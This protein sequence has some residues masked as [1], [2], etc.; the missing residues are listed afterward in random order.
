MFSYTIPVFFVLLLAHLVLALA[1][2]EAMGE[3]LA[4]GLA[5]TVLVAL[6]E[7][8][9]DGDDAALL[10]AFELF[11]GSVAQPTAKT[12]A[13]TIEHRSVMRPTRFIFRL[14][15]SFASFEQD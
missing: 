7:G 15:I 3:G 5:A 2:G 1:E 13:S 10:G 6:G 14:L 8:D 4:T 9:V 12:I 11:S